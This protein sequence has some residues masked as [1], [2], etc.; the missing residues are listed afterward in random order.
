[1]RSSQ[2]LSVLNWTSLSDRRIKQMKTLMFKTVNE[3]L[4][5]L[6][7]STGLFFWLLLRVED[8]HDVTKALWVLRDLEF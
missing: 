1:M 5:K 7:A 3:Q 2:I 4:S 8:A 6:P